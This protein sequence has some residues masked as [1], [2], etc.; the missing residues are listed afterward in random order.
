MDAKHTLLAGVVVACAW[1]GVAF[2]GPEVTS[3]HFTARFERGALTALEDASG[4]VFVSGPAPEEG[5]AIHR[6]AGAHWAEPQEAPGGAVSPGQPSEARL[7]VGG[8]AG[9]AIATACR[10]E[11]DSGDLVLSQR[12]ESPEPGVWG[13]SWAIAHIP[14][15]M[16]I[17]VPGRSGIQLTAT[18]PGAEHTFDYPMAWEAQLVVVEGEG[19]GFYVWADDPSGAF[20]RL[21]VHRTQEGW[22]LDLTTENQA[23][24]DGLTRC[25]SVAWHVNVYEGDWRVPARRYRD[26]A[27]RHF[28]PTPVAD[29]HP[30]W[31]KDIRCCVIMGMNADLIEALA[32]RLD[33]AQTLLYIP[34][35]RASGYDRDYPT[36]DAP[37]DALAPFVERAHA[38]GYRV[39]LHVNYFGVDP[40]N[41]LYEQFEPYQVRSAWGKH[42]KQWWLW[43]KADPVIKFAY[44]NPACKAWRDVFVERMAQLCGDYRIDA[45]HLDQTL[46]VFN[47]HNGLVDGMSMAEGNV[48]LHEDLRRALPEVALSGEGL[49]EITYRHEAFAQRHAWGLHHH[50][51]TWN[52]G[53]LECAHPIASYLL[54]PYTTIYGYLG[55]TP[56]SRGQLYAAWNEAY[57]HWG[58][59]PTLKP[60]PGSVAHPDGFA[61]QLFDEIALWQG[62]RVD[63]DLDSAW[64]QDVAFPFVTARGERVIRTMD[65]RLMCGAREVSRTLAGVREVRLPGSV[66]GWRLYDADRLFGLDPEVWY[67]YF[68]EPRDPD[69][70]HIEAMPD[71]FTVDR[72]IIAD[73]FALVTTR[74][75]GGVIAELATLVSKAVCGSERFDGE[76]FEGRGDLGTPDG[77]Q[78]CGTGTAIH[79]HPPWR[80]GVSGTAYGEFHVKLPE[81]GA[82][83]FVSEVAMDA[84]AVGEGRTDGVTYRAMAKAGGVEEH[85]EVHSASSEP[86]P[87]VLDLT[88][89]A[90]QAIDLR[91]SIHPGPNRSPSFD[92]ARWYAPRIEQDI[93]TEG[94]LAIAGALP[95]HMAIAGTSAVPLVS[96][97][98]SAR[99]RAAFPGGVVLLRDVPPA[100]VLPL[101]IEQAS[102]HTAFVRDTGAVLDAP[103]NACAVAQAG[104]VG[105]V[106]RPG[107][108]THPPDQGA[109]IV[110]VPL[111]L[112]GEPA[113]LHTFVGLRDGS[114]S[115]GVVFAINVNGT[116]LAREEVV[117]GAWH[118]LTVDLTPWAGKAVV[119]VLIADADGA[120]I[121][122]WAHWGEPVIR[123][124][125]TASPA[126]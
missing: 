125:G 35:W 13:V 105:G 21:V 103:P 89:F 74:Q 88:R 104:T 91:L 43:T 78:F 110:A 96:G 108:F 109:T 11:A 10:I 66:P 42:E 71:G 48:A 65:K 72:I 40:L 31:V 60:E 97:Q 112:P 113:E 100:A 94:D 62:E 27:A 8:L 45:L 92:W 121:C 2:G 50:N 61:R 119:V 32:E 20:K 107:L 5:A 84:G 26:W 18:S 14:L 17:L 12:A 116:E 114:E 22:R 83:R 51:G 58:V 3:E 120:Y 75:V 68:D 6:V 47:D 99:I 64:P 53:L 73:D 69:A 86:Q 33:P 67:P 87:L 29:Q 70:F 24:F 16:N 63:I 57:E 52:L 46:C 77:A 85:A 7:A 56:P 90:G 122:D 82:I 15:D 79:A 28:G 41:P 19:R 30:S 25:D 95:W 38:L 81:A 54:E 126:Q 55:Y 36:Y 115:E 111:T 44:I 23:P 118:E 9:G 106:S 1:P 80:T 124:K 4:H 76:S 49:N 37:V 102:F 123:G 101:A 93:A 59:I 98:R 39:M 34:S 117:P